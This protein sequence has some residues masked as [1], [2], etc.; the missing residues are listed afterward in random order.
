MVIEQLW[1]V[2]SFHSNV[3]FK[4]ALGFPSGS[5]LFT[6]DFYMC[7]DGG[8]RRGQYERGDMRQNDRGGMREVT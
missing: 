5:S 2:L 3:I 7:E 1:L 8:M 4:L 6:S